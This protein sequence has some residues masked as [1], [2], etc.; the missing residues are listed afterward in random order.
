[1]QDLRVLPRGAL[2]EQR[3]EVAGLRAQLGREA[4]VLGERV[5]GRSA[6]PVD[7]QPGC[8]RRQDPGEA[9]ERLPARPHDVRLPAV[10]RPFERGN[11]ARAHER[12]L[13]DARW[14]GDRDERLLAESPRDARDLA[15]AAEEPIGVGLL[16][17]R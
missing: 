9:R 12:R 6:A 16:E 10:A 2:A 15:T 17:R 7:R 14:T 1:Q 13:A 4:V 11:D 3:T 5:R 8:E